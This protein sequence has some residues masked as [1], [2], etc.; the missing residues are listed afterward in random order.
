MHCIGDEC[1]SEPADAQA[2]GTRTGAGGIVLAMVCAALGYGAA[3]MARDR[4]PLPHLGQAMPPP[5]SVSV[6]P[7]S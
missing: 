6:L 7:D 3:S 1:Q 2:S 5:V 4:A